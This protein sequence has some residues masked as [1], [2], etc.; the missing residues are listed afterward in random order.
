[1]EVVPGHPPDGAAGGFA[2]SRSRYVAPA[3]ATRVRRELGHILDTS[4]R[5][6]AEL[7][8]ITEVLH[9][10]TH[11]DDLDLAHPVRNHASAFSTVRFPPERRAR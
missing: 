11:G 2:R 3:A 8:V 10:I 4:A 7:V 6:F 5:R 1:M 9:G